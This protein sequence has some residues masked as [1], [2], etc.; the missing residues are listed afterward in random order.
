ML[1]NLK[2]MITVALFSGLAGLTLLLQDIIIAH[3][4]GVGEVVDAYQL[5]IAFPLLA[6]NVFAGGT[7]LA[8]LVPV[9][10]RYSVAGWDLHAARLVQLARR[11][12][13]GVLLLVCVI[14]ALTYPQVIALVAGGFSVF[15]LNLSV[16]LLW[17]MIPALLFAGLAGIDAAVLNCRKRFLFIS[18]LPAFMPVGVILCVV[19]LGEWLGIYAAALGLVCGA[20]V[21]WVLSRSI[22]TPLLQQIG[23]IG[24]SAAPAPLRAQLLRDYATAAASAALLG[25]ILLTDMFI[26]STLPTGSAATYGYAIRPVLLLLAFVTA[27]V[28]NVLLSVFSH[29]VANKDWPTLKNQ[30]LL[31]VGLLALGSLP[32]VALWH[33]YAVELMALLYQ[34]GA[35]DATDTANVAAVQQIYLLQIPFYL[36]AVIGVRVMNSLNQHTT[37]L[38]IAAV[39]F[40]ANLAVDVWFS[41]LLGLQAIAWGT[42]L[43]IALWASL[44]LICLSR[45]HVHHAAATELDR[46]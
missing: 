11:T 25:G 40:F 41:P 16:Y 14:W 44:I 5:A 3:H 13:G 18:T 24:S 8:V 32:L 30:T 21:Q 31:W 45:L 26:A 19:L 34:R 28:G 20:A 42:N 15:A 27:I 4:F 23:K 37:L 1:G 12:L 33:A 2:S 17:L 29:L 38:V 6:V 36:V 22:T 10:A 7:L 35:F 39:C 43:A 9:L 46:V